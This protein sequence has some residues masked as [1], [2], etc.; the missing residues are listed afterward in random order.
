MATKTSDPVL[1]ILTEL[2]R[3]TSRHYD[4]RTIEDAI[5]TYNEMVKENSE[6]KKDVVKANP[7]VGL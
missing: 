5:K 6:L 3:G 1:N 2:K 4:S 7:Q